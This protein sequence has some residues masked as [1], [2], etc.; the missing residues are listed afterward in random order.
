MARTISTKASARRSFAPSA[1]SLD[2]GACARV[3]G[4]RRPGWIAPHARA[5][6]LRTGV[7]RSEWRPRCDRPGRSRGVFE[8]RVQAT[9]RPWKH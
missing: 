7:A 8:L 9:M 3:H 6:A 4:G 1:R 5:A 2:R